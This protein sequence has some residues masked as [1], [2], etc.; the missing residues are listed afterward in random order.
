MLGKALISSFLIL[1]NTQYSEICHIPEMPHTLEISN[2]LKTL[3]ILKIEQI[4]I[5]ICNLASFF[6]HLSSSYLVLL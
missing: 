5:C 4:L 6:H 3:D 1:K 2:I